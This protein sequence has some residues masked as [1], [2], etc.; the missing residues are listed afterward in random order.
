MDFSYLY[1]VRITKVIPTFRLKHCRFSGSCDHMSWD[2]ISK[3]LTTFC[4]ELKFD[5][6]NLL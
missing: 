3:A 2:D 6:M 4:G 5:L 1:T